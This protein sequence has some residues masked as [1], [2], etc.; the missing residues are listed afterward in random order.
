MGRHLLHLLA[1][2][3]LVSAFFAVW[4]GESRRS[5]LRIGGGLLAG[6]I[7]VS[8]LLAW[9]MYVFTR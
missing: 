2:S 3:G 6:M 5:R 8:L 1:F 7:G 4:A 9:I